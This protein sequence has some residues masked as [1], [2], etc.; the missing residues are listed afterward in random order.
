LKPGDLLILTADHGND[1]TWK[2]TDHTREQVPV[3]SFMPGL[4]PGS[5]G[6][7]ESFADVGQTVASHLGSAP[8]DAGHA[9]SLD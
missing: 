5:V 8:L 1:P 3:M 7:R 4:T 2:G 6:R 9:W